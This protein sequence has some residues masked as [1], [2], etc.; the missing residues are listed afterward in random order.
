MGKCL[1]HQALQ[2]VLERNSWVIMLITE[3]FLNQ[4]LQSADGRG[5]LIFLFRARQS[6][7]S[8]RVSERPAPLSV[9]VDIFICSF[10]VSIYI[11]IYIFPFFSL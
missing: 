5:G 8:W 11:F 9:C 7:E 3:H 2:V 4:M 6:R 1:K 10:L